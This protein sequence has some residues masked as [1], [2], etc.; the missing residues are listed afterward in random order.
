[1]TMGRTYTYKFEAELL[2]P[3]WPL[4]ALLKPL[5]SGSGLSRLLPFDNLSINPTAHIHSSSTILYMHLCN[6]ISRVFPDV[7][8]GFSS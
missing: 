1:M 6:K 2:E 4:A 5:E 7:R 8:Q 3:S